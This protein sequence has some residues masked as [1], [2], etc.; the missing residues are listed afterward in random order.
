MHKSNRLVVR[1]LLLLVGPL[2]I[3][4]LVFLHPGSKT[5]DVRFGLGIGSGG[6]EAG[7][8]GDGKREE[9]EGSGFHGEGGIGRG[10]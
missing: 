2:Q 5:G 8:Q 10:P 1:L 6:R 7:Q 4:L 3:F 9:S